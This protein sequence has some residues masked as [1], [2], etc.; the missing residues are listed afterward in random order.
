MRKIEHILHN[1][2][3]SEQQQFVRSQVLK[4]TPKYLKFAF[5][6]IL[7]L[8]FSKAVGSADP[9]DPKLTG[10]LFSIF[11]S[12]AYFFNFFFKKMYNGTNNL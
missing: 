6:C 10:P 3:P 2:G 4:L 7:S 12:K 9:T 11:I 5:Y 8:Q 1:Q